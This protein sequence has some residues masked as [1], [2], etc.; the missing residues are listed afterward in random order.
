MKRDILYVDDEADNLV[1][2][3]AT[4]E[5][6]FNVW[7]AS[8]G[9]EALEMMEQRAFP[10]VV[11][12]QR[13]PGMTGVELFELMRQ[14]FPLAKRIMLTGYADSQAIVDAINQGRIYHFIKKPWEHDLVFSIITR[15]IEA[16]DLELS[17]NT[18]TDRLVHNDRCAALGRVAARVAHEM[19]NQLCMLPLLEFIE[20][21][22]GDQRELMEMSSVTRKMY[23]RLVEL[24]SEVKDF[25]RCR[26]QGASL[27]VIPL[28]E[29]IQELIE[30][31]RYD[32][33]LSASRLTARINGTAWVRANKVNLQQVL[34]N[35][36]KNA[37]YAI[38]DCPDGRVALLIDRDETT[39][40]ITVADNGCGM[41]PEVR[42]HIWE[43]FYTT[44]G[45]EGTGL[46]LDLVKSIVEAH[47][48]TIDCQ[49]APDEGATFTIRLPLAA[50]PDV[51]TEAPLIASGGLES[52][53]SG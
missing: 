40:I 42:E 20:E 26:H 27:Q 39:A 22:Y 17:N 23:E 49:S 4:F 7:T 24:V 6:D 41:A 18:L 48:G 9:P 35:L 33:S 37:A 19:G 51:K 36:I 13:M 43:S 45:E 50:P 46:G 47:D 12:D 38:R 3:E 30:F 25:V 10:V 29:A 44:K 34:I 31:L 21:N 14:R 32:G 15:A 52:A 16:H 8:S 53:H 1:V 5:D 11:A 28:S 2:F